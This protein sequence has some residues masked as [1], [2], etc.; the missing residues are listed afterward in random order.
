[1]LKYYRAIF[2][3]IFKL[4]P[5]NTQIFWTLMLTTLIN[6]SIWFQKNIYCFANYNYIFYVR[7]DG[8]LPSYESLI[9]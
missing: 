2:H 9:Y 4:L 1:M 3:I 8:I 5:Y 6:K 7:V